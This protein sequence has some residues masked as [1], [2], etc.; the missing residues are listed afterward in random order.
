LLI[1]IFNNNLNFKIMKKILV[2]LGI[3]LF[4]SCEKI[5]IIEE[6]KQS[7]ICEFLPP[8]GETYFFN[9]DEGIWYDASGNVFAGSG[10]RMKADDD[11]YIKSVIISEAN[12][13]TDITRQ[14]DGSIYYASLSMIIG[15]YLYKVIVTDND[16]LTWQG[17]FTHT[18]KIYDK[19]L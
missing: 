17:E 3:V 13:T 16:D 5:V 19:N 14:H 11:G 10:F 18:V 9:V 6:N 2:L 12:D 8:T 4:F 7:P 1:K 15:K